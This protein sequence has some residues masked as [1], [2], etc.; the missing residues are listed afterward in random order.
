MWKLFRVGRSGKVARLSILIMRLTYD[1]EIID[2][3]GCGE[4]SQ[5]GSDAKEIISK[6]RDQSLTS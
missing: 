6:S 5:V 4:K 3:Y 2:N 1:D